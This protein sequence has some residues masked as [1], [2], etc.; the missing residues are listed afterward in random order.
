MR[1][2]KNQAELMRHRGRARPAGQPTSPLNALRGLMAEIGLVAPRGRALCVRSYAPGRPDGFD[3][4][5]IVAPDCVAL[6]SLV[7]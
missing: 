4:G 1:S 7:G 2:I 3:D 5:E 6:G